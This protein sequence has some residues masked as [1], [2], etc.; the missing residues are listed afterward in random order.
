MGWYGTT[1]MTV[2]PRVCPICAR[3][4]APRVGNKAFPFC[5]RS[6]KLVDLGRWLDGSYRMPGSD[7]SS[8]DTD[9][10]SVADDGS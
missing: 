10:G 2:S 1:S 7:G 4:V 9:E 6:C 5:S 8:A 3:P